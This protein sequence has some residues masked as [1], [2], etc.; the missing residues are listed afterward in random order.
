[1]VLLAC[2]DLVG[3]GSR[4]VSDADVL[5]FCEVGPVRA[6]KRK[7]AEATIPNERLRNGFVQGEAVSA[8]AQQGMFTVPVRE[9]GR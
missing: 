8:A 2:S 1:V 7:S 9:L 5:M 4:G 3:E 6:D